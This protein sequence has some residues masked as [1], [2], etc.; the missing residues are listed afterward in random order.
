MEPIV[1]DPGSFGGATWFLV[2]F[3]SGMIASFVL[4]HCAGG[5]EGP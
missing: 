4:Y 1:I 3:I 5:W 2:G